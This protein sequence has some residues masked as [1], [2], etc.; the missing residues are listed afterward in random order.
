MIRLKGLKMG[1][2]IHNIP[3]M[4]DAKIALGSDGK[5]HFPALLIYE[6]TQQCDLIK[7]SRYR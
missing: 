2:R 7:A 6:E 5:L 3:E 4:I 1:Q